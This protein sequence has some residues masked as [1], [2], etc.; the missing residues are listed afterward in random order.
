MVVLTHCAFNTGRI[1]DGWTGAVLSRLD[2][3]VALFFVVSGFLLARPRLEAGRTGA[4][5]P[6]LLGYLR[7]RALRILP[8]YWVVVVAALLIDPANRRASL[9]DW[10][11][12]LTLTQIYRPA[13]LASSLTQMWS[14]CTEVAFYLMLPV[15]VRV[16]LIGGFGVRRVAVRC[17]ALSILGLGFGAAA[18]LL[19][20]PG[21]HVGQWLPVYLPWFLGGVVLAALS[22]D[23][24]ASKR[25]AAT[26]RDLT[27][28]WTL[29]LGLFAL[30]CSDLAGPR[31]LVPP[32]AWEA[33]A[34][35]LLYGGAALCL[36]VPLVFGDQLAGPVRRWMA[37]PIPTWLGDI[38]Y[39][40]FCIH[41]LVLVM[42]MRLLNVEVFTGHFTLVLAVT[43]SVSLVAATLSRR[44]VEGPFLRL[45]PKPSTRL[46]IDPATTATASNADH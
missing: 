18:P 9:A 45:K 30:A 6:G 27:G 33:L 36:V 20:E 34:K 13:P 41:M 17:A 11:S 26:S 24:H 42:A 35:S 38:S 22:A 14:L 1:N 21:T 12:T 5:Q 37:G 19:F 8:L 28:W 4:P 2:F 31:L 40:V 32:T 23:P 15:L 39:G 10:I 43:L 7:K 16:L 44:F 3:G 46:S 29:A 25:L